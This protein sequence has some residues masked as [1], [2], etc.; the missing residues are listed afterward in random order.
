MN[1][2]TAG[3][4]IVYRARDCGIHAA[5]CTW[6][7][8][9]CDACTSSFSVSLEHLK[10]SAKEPLNASPTPSLSPIGQSHPGGGSLNVAQS[11][12]KMSV[13][14]CCSVPSAIH[15]VAQT[16]LVTFSKPVS[17]QLESLGFE[18]VT[19]AP[20]RSLLRHSHPSSSGF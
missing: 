17:D 7:Q 8:P 16:L 15:H 2:P 20:P 5:C 10:L 1:A 14:G 13:T 6:P 19:S 12:G 9:S 18:I 3:K 11:L 4:Q